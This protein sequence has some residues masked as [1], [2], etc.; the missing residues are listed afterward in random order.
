ML[1]AQ[2]LAIALPALLREAPGL[3]AD[4]MAIAA[5]PGVTPEELEAKAAEIL[6]DTYA[7]LVPNSQ[8][9]TP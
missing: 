4:F 3:Y 1:L 6:G 8:L 2:I 9:P 5:K 7:G